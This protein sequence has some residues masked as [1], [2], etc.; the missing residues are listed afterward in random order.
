MGCEDKDNDHYPAPG[1]RFGDASKPRG[2]AVGFLDLPGTIRRRIYEHV[3]AVERPVYLFQDFVPR[4]EAFAPDKP[5]WWI[6]LL[7]TNRQ[8]SSEAKTVLYGNNNFHLMDNP[9]KHGTLLQSFLECVGSSNATFLSRLCISFPVAE[10]AQG[11]P[12]AVTI[13]QDSLHTLNI[14]QEKCTGLKTLEMQLCRENSGLLAG[15]REED[16]QRVRDALA[17]ID[18]QLKAIPSVK[19]V[20]VRLYIKNLPSL[21]IDAMRGLAWAVLD[22]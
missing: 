15:A 14:V 3:L 9:Q 11:Q 20:V 22:G 7:Y 1:T 4:V 19:K 8:I 2:S 16:A 6:A 5:K 18:A 12:H 13:R 17:R 21:I 10:K